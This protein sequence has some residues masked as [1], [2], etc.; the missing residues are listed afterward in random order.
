MCSCLYSQC[1]SIDLLLSSFCAVTIKACLMPNIEFYFPSPG[2]SALLEAK[3]LME[4]RTMRAKEK[5]RTWWR[6]GRGHPIPPQPLSTL[7]QENRSPED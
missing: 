4:G 7:K 5:S 6:C 3:G 2:L 1:S